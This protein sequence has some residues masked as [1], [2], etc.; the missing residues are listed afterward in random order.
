MMKI[1]WITSSNFLNVDDSIVFSLKETYDI[2]WTILVQREMSQYFPDINQKVQLI[3]VGS[4]CKLLPRLS[5]I[6]TL[7]IYI[8]VAM[9]IKKRKPDLIYVDCLGMPYLFPVL[10]V[11]GFDR[12]K[13]V[14][15]CHDFVDHVNVPHRRYISMYKKFIF[16]KFVNF[17]FFSK[18][19]Q[20]LFKTTYSNKRSFYTPLVLQQ[21]GP[22]TNIEKNHEKKTVVFLFYGAIREN[23]GLEFLIEAANKLPKTYDGTYKIKIYGD[24]NKWHYYQ[25]MIHNIQNFDLKIERVPDN[26]VANLF[27]SADYL[28]LPYRDVSQSGPL[29]VAYYYNLPVIASNHDGFKE[30]IH[31]NE[32]GFLFKNE[33][34]DDLSR[35]LREIIDG[36]HDYYAIKRNL[37]QFVVSNLSTNKIVDMYIDGLD[38]LYKEIYE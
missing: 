25:N 9:E 18:T 38:T 13:I 4:C 33:D 17:K 11:C 3:G 12:N 37:K 1:E 21:Y 14:Y 2:N 16:K 32:N 30:F 36:K 34:S 23:K 29:S 10:F 20:K 5:S 19:Q 8:K 31:N 15:A 22:I 6:R 28:V 7:Y 27:A 35:V 24:T 26:E